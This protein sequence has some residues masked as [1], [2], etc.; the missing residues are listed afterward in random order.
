[1][2]NDIK[3]EFPNTY[4]L[5]TYQMGTGSTAWGDQRAVF[6]GSLADG[7][8][9]FA[10]DGLFDAWP[11]A[12]YRPAFITRQAEPTDVTIAMTGGEVGPQT[13]DFTAEVCVE[14]GGI[15]KTMRIYMIDALDHYPTWSW[16]YRSGFRQ[17]A[18]T[19][20]VTVEPDTCTTVTNQFEFDATSWADQ[21]NIRIIAWAQEPL[22]VY[23]AEVHQAAELAWPFVSDP[24]FFEDDFESGDFIMWARTT[25]P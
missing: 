22:S 8:P 11:I 23:P 10:Y 5:V 2:V 1:V 17:A 19:V 18:D 3:E 7:L 14:A 6:F 24:S 4:I 20:D 13:Y 21:Q 12:N 9:W 16:Y 15:G 25:T